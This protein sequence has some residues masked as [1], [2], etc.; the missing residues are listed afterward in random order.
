MSYMYS[1]RSE[2]TSG[3]VKKESMSRGE[4]LEE[5]ESER[6]RVAGCSGFQFF[7]PQS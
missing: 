5:E 4:V 7:A 2:I 6:E 1:Y 3:L